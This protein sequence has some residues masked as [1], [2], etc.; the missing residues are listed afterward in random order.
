M[1]RVY[2]RDIHVPRVRDA[3]VVRYSRSVSGSRIHRFCLN[4]QDSPSTHRPRPRTVSPLSSSAFL[5]CPGTLRTPVFSSGYTGLRLSAG[6]RGL[7]SGGGHGGKAASSRYSPPR[8]RGDAAVMPCNLSFSLVFHQRKRQIV[9]CSTP[10]RAASRGGWGARR[11]F[12]AV[13]TSRDQPPYS[14]T[15]TRPGVPIPISRNQGCEVLLAHKQTGQ[16]KIF[17]CTG[18]RKYVYLLFP[19]PTFRQWRQITVRSLYTPHLDLQRRMWK[20]RTEKTFTF[21]SLWMVDLAIL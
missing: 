1:S 9:R 5:V 8:C 21:W 6:I 18:T 15:Q 19:I 16:A 11:C 2:P 20:G 13:T 7:V 10:W 12:A 3:A 14:R 17:G 4:L